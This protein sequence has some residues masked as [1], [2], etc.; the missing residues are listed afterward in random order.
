MHQT[1]RGPGAAAVGASALG[2]TNS[3]SNFVAQLQTLS[4]SARRL[5][6]GAAAPATTATKG[7]ARREVSVPPLLAHQSD[8]GRQSSTRSLGGG[9][10]IPQLPHRLLP[11]PLLS[12]KDTGIVPLENTNDGSSLLLASVQDVSG[13]V[14]RRCYMLRW[15]SPNDDERS[16][17]KSAV[18]RTL[19]NSSIGQ[20]AMEQVGLEDARS[21]RVTRID[22]DDDEEMGFLGGAW[23]GLR[24]GNIDGPK[25]ALRKGGKKG[26]HKKG[27]RGSVTFGQEEE[28]KRA[29]ESGEDDDIGVIDSDDDD[30]DDNSGT[31]T[32]V[33]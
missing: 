18:R 16:V 22:D 33:E 4:N 29:G 25:S 32:D 30:D 15:R 1:P 28:I 10:D 7:A 6:A 14:G 5:L 24:R 2:R 23:S 27:R 21:E 19:L 12:Q 11:R 20:L 31:D 13:Q 17:M 26:R 3:R 8:G 9:G